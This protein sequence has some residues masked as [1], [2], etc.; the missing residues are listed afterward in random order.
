MA[1]PVLT[2]LRA[3]ARVLQRRVREREPA[4]LRR[5]RRVPECAKLDEE[6]L[7][8]GVQRRHCLAA[9]AR[10]L[11]FQSWIH[12]RAV[13]SGEEQTDFGTLLYPEG[14][15]GHCNIWSASYDE[16][17]EIR[18]AHGGYLLA[19]KRQY[20]IVDRFFIESIGLDP[21]NPDWVLMGRDWARPNDVAARGRQYRT[22]IERTLGA[23]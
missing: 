22:L 7:V 6:S 9:V 2:Q 4:A 18:A 16:A 14:C 15:V 5:L 10:Q 11:G 12:A 13:L 23:C 19:Y 21:E 17:R 3:H 1:E 20:F 8:G